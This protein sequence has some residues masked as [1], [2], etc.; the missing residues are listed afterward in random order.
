VMLLSDIQQIFAGTWPPP[1]EGESPSAVERIFSKKLVEALC[2][3]GD[4][5]WNE[6]NRGKPITENWLARHVGRFE[7]HSTTL[8][9]GDGRAKGYQ[10]ADFAA[11]FDRYLSGA[12]Q[13]NRDSV[14]CQEKDG[15]EA[16]TEPSLVTD[17]KRPATEE[18]SRCHAQDTLPR[19]LQG[20]AEPTL[21]VIEEQALLFPLS[22]PDCFPID[23]SAHCWT[24][25]RG[26]RQQSSHV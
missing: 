16:V 25:W 9:I 20:S 17:E 1:P 18:M 14:T 24:G 4:R 12:G 21:Q 13:F 26:P 7:I 23:R 11:A 22:P 6:A 2:E 10:K 8:R 19:D 3:M 15:F 5:P